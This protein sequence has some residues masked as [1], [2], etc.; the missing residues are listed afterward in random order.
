MNSKMKLANNPIQMPR[1]SVGGYWPSLFV[2]L[3]EK[4]QQHSVNNTANNPATQ[5]EDRI[6]GKF[7]GSEGST[8][9]VGD[10]CP[11]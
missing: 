1:T 8:E 7:Y 2:Q 11:G 6:C 10:R 5:A 9:V 4:V 3:T